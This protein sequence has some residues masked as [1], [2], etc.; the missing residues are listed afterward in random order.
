[1][2]A[3]IDQAGRSLSSSLDAVITYISAVGLRMGKA[4]EEQR[5]TCT[6]GEHLTVLRATDISLQ[7][8]YETGGLVFVCR[9]TVAQ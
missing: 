1:M 6:K 2:V 3:S 9:L 4:N 5:A 8:P 7:R